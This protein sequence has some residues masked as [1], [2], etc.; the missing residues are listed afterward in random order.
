V[1]A[2]SLP[3]AWALFILA[4]A[5]AA[6]LHAVLPGRGGHL[7]DVPCGN[8]HLADKDVT[9]ANAS[10]LIA[11][12]EV[13]CVRCHADALKMSHPSGISPT[14]PLPAGYP[15]DWKG[16]MT[17]STC[18][19]P[20]G[21]N[22][23]LLR[24]DKRAK[25]MCLTCHDETFFLAM[26]DAGTSIAPS[27]HLNATRAQLL[28]IDLDPYSLECL[29]CHGTMGDGPRVSVSRNG[30]IRH[31]SGAANHPIGKKYGDA[32]GFGGYRPERFLSKAV[33]LPGGKISCVSC[34]QGYTKDHGKLVT[35]MRGS[36]LCFE[37]HDL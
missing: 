4:A 25:A 16:D 24:G 10:K 1:S 18:H 8:C 28:A 20:H 35:P 2:S 37:C 9:K 7:A 12:Q 22:Q 5:V 31:G 17:C 6:S 14:R 11:A 21:S 32:V 29:A 36:E 33:W 23:G 30:V 34:H 15:A 26:K 13:L 3:R 27:G 19:D